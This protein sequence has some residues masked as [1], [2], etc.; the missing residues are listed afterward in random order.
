MPS[1]WKEWEKAKKDVKSDSVAKPEA[2]SEAVRIVQSAQ[3]VAKS[4]P[5]SIRCSQCGGVKFK[6]IRKNTEWSCRSCGHI[7]TRIE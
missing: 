7:F 3:R 2:V 4:N 5:G 1:R 6:T